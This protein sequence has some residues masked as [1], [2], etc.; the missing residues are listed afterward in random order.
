MVIV[1]ASEKLSVKRLSVDTTNDVERVGDVTQRLA[2][3]AAFGVA[4]ETM[5]IDDLTRQLQVEHDHAFDP[6]EQN[7]QPACN[8]LVETRCV[9]VRIFS[10]GPAQD[11]YTWATN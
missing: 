6:K 1:V 10:V 5:A 9:K 11:T 3:R 8:M 7:V 2:H 4:N